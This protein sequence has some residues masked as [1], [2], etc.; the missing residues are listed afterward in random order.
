MKNK[1]IKKVK[2]TNKEK[3]FISVFILI[4]KFY[5]YKKFLL[6]NNTNHTMLF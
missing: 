4:I 1:K 5:Y 6:L 2:D 3:F